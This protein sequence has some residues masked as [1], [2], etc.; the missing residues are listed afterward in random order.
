[1]NLKELLTLK[2]QTHTAS[3]DRVA[4]TTITGIEIP[5]DNKDNF[6]ERFNLQ[7]KA[8]QPLRQWASESLVKAL[9]ATIGNSIPALHEFVYHNDIHCS[10]YKQ[11]G[12]IYDSKEYKEWMNKQMTLFEN[13]EFKVTAWLDY[14][15]DTTFAKYLVVSKIE[16]HLY[17]R[18]A[19]DLGDKYLRYATVTIQLN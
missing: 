15:C 6:T 11:L 14:D 2:E 18:S 5:A 1:M 9:E 4:V 19:V 12:I 7:W 8:E 10:D 13:D 17:H 16:P 3:V